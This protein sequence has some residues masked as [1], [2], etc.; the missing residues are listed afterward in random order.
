MGR[1]G[2]L[3]G[4]FDPPHIGHLFMAEE[5]RIKMDLDEVWWMPNRIPPHKE[6]ESDTTERDRVDMIQSMVNLHPS[7]AL[8]DIELKREGPSYTYDTVMELRGKYPNEEFFFIIG[9]DSLETL[10]SWHKG[11]DLKK[12]ITFIVIRRPGYYY[13]KKLSKGITIIE[14]PTID[15]SSSVIR[16]TIYHKKCNRFLLTN[17]VF[18]IIKER[19]LYE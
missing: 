16:E 11:Q 7:F 3:G 5:A 17:D 15:V 12:L 1:I 14:G 4:T 8:C 9:E 19:Q 6:K 13:E 2:I 10:D 18:S